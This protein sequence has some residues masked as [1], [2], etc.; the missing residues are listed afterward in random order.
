M[1]KIL[2]FGLLALAILTLVQASRP[3]SYSGL[4]KYLYFSPCDTPISY[5]I[6]S[7]DERFGLN[8]DELVVN[9]DDATK[10]WESAIGKD[11]FIQ[12]EDGK[13]SVNLVYDK[14]QSLS[15]QI[16]DL[17][18]MLKNQESSLKPSVDQY[19]TLAK[20]FKEKM[21]KLNQDIDYW[22]QQGDAPEEEYNKLI[23]RQ[24]ELQSEAEKLNLLASTLNQ[25]AND[26]NASVNNLNQ[27]V[28]SFNSELAER[29]EEGIYDPASNKIEIYFIVNKDEL[30]H[31]IGHEFGHALGLGHIENKKAIMSPSSNQYL[32][33]T[34]DDVEALNAL[35]Q[36]RSYIELYRESLGVSIE[37]LMQ[38]FSKSE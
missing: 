33:P 3:E 5:K 12:S 13:V 9:V 4:T 27:T 16:Q 18:E 30:V 24:Q 23:Q 11:L 17:Q 2:L 7:I 35:C 1:R 38:N 28:S 19:E 31:T 34:A 25:T 14:R 29:P 22:N 37:N 15:T 6:D 32:I 21:A 10:I 8:Y 36:N 20:E 26:Y